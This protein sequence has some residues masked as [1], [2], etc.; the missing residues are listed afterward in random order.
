MVGV[1]DFGNLCH[2]TRT[3]QDSF[4]SP[5]PFTSNPEAVEHPGIAGNPGK[6]EI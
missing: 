3:V 4:C 5:F 6:Q 2:C 1:Q